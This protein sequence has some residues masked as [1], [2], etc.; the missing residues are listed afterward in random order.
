LAGTR[1]KTAGKKVRK[2]RAS[3]ARKSALRKA[4]EEV[5]ARLSKAGFE[6]VFAGG[7][8]RDM[9][10]GE[11][12]KDYDIATSATPQAV[13]EIFPR[14]YAVGAQFGVVVVL[15]DGYQFEVATFRVDSTYSDGRHP[16]AVEFGDARA[17]VMRRD[18]TINGMLYDPKKDK[19][20]DYVDGQKDLKGKVIRCIG[21]PAERFA[22]DKLRMLR[23]VRFS[24]RLGFEIE[25]ATRE[26]IG[27]LAPQI[28]VVSQERIKAELE[29]IL[30]CAA[31]VQG[32][33]EMHSLGLLRPILPEAE[34]MAHVQLATETLLDHA[35]AVLDRLSEP[36][37]E[38]A[39]AGLLH[40]CAGAD[41]QEVVQESARLV[42]VA[43]RRLKC[44]NSERTAAAWLVLNQ[45]ALQDAKERRLSYLKR[46]FAH[47]EFEKLLA[48][49]KAK[50]AVGCADS[51]DFEFVSR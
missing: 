33:S 13:Q 46:L 1:K 10:M 5:A 4:A 42:S 2:G 16:D 34:A 29:M 3:R 6:A 32:I 43:A 15:H 25:S 26:A 40:C 20:I 30:T 27:R 18:F 7:C 24:A 36:S 49:F 12:P 41:E 51:R 48:L 39:L 50:T 47:G 44:S 11:E 17:D 35:L 9:V 38:L 45:F 14:T 19:V 8:V 37:F 21:E 31:G 23:A 22:E 28:T